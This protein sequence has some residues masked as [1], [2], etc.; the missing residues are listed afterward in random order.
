MK[1]PK[2][3][4]VWPIE[5]LKPYDK[6]PRTHPEEQIKQLADSIQEFGFNNPI[7]V[8][9]KDGIVTGHGRLVAAKLLKMKEVPVIVLDHLTEKQKRAYIIADNKLT[10]NSQWNEDILAEHLQELQEQDYDLDL[11]GFS[12]HE[13]VPFLDPEA[14]GSDPE[15]EWK[16]M[17][18][19]KQEDKTSFQSI[20]VHF[21]DQKGVDE[22]ARLIN[23]KLTNKTRS[24]WYPQ[25]IIE[26]ALDKRYGAKS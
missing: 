6:N 12:E 16:G 20:H 7:G 5:R 13:L 8:D 11:T 4:E 10:L 19:F 17:P 23:Q 3:I 14:E 26:K 18:E 15:K 9:S 2:K 24:I 25:P 22:F 1:Y 21:F